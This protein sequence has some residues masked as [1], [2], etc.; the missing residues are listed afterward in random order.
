[1]VSPIRRV[2]L[3]P[4]WIIA[5]LWPLVLLA[6]SV[7][8]LPRPG[9]G[10]LTWRQ[11]LSLAFLFCLTLLFI[12]LAGQSRDWLSSARHTGLLPLTLFVLWSAAS[13]F[14]AD[15]PFPAFHHTLTW[16]A[17]LLFFVFIRL[18]A[19]RP[20]ELRLTVKVLALVCLI[21]SASTLLGSWSGPHQ[22][23]GSSGLGEPS[24]VMTPF[25]AALALRLRQ[26]RAAWLCGAVAAFSWATVLQ[27]TERAP[28][29][30]A[31]VA[32]ILLIPICA[33]L[34]RFRPHSYRR[35]LVL[36]CA[37][38]FVVIL[39]STPSLL[40]QERK[41]P[42]ITR[43]QA[44]SGS[45]ANTRARLLFWGVALEMFR[46][47]PLRGVGANNYEVAFPEA[48]AQFSERHANSTKLVEMNE[49][50]LAQRAHNEYLQILAE[51]GVVGL[52][53]FMAFGTG[54]MWAAWR[55]LKYAR[56][57]LVPAAVTALVAFTLSSGASSISFRWMGSGLLFFFMAA[58]VSHFALANPA[59]AKR[60]AQPRPAFAH[61]AHG[62][63][64]AF[65]CLMLCGMSAQAANVLLHGMAYSTSD[66]ERAD[67]L[68]RSAL[69]W[70]PYDA[71]THFTYGT[72]LLK[73]ERASEAVPHLRYAAENGFNSSLCYA[74]L[75][76]AE[77]ATG[78][79]KA[80]EQ[81]LSQAVKVYPRSVFLRV[82]HAAA[83]TKLGREQEAGQESA[84]ALAIDG[85]AA[86]GWHELIF[87]GL[88]AAALAARTD[89]N[90][91]LPGELQPEGCVFVILDENKERPRLLNFGL[92]KHN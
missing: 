41:R 72:W 65:S 87:R 71:A 5:T 31:S 80:A 22:V 59:N 46:A 84:A 48:R 60:K 32:L 79:H 57:P 78:D 56:S 24:A 34:P 29:I 8:G 62:I 92:A 13:A 83:L 69:R 42:V 33:A 54:L 30:G 77:T 68:Y 63:A 43:L 61:W 10:S 89:A 53:A 40:L 35:P 50:F 49:G 70:N 3:K 1:M 58:L 7:P 16:G 47:H 18:I 15:N 27:S 28:F 2:V 75:V 38:A 67:A 82:R 85:R 36:L 45:E 52:A 74:Y 37:F 6:P 64:L 81:T 73:R 90:I 17:Y 9:N 51:L 39:Y 91:A 4:H 19:E 66:T 23:I 44:T 86:R 12:K 76:A 55:A 25:F 20:R 14:W 21:I 26:P 88:D 11:E